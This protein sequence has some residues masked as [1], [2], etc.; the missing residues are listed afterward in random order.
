MI[1]ANLNNYLILQKVGGMA[2]IMPA[3]NSQQ[4]PFPSA[5]LDFIPPVAWKRG[6][7]RPYNTARRSLTIPEYQ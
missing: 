5:R 3:I 6:Y 1:V 4:L 2:G 7:F